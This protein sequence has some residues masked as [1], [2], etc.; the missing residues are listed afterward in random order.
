MKLDNEN[1]LINIFVYVDDIS[2]VID[3]KNMIERFV[4]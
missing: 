2:F 3:I 1:L 4:T